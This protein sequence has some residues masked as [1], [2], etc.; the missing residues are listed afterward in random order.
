VTAATGHEAIGYARKNAPALVLLD[1]HMPGMGGDEVIRRLRAD[2]NGL[3]IL[4]LSGDPISAAEL[5]ALGADGAV[6]KPFDV[7]TLIAQIRSHVT[8]RASS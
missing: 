8:S 5:K 4:I 6:Q 1:K 7:P 2:F 3:P